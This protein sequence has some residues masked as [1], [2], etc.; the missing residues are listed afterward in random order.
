MKVLL[1]N[2]TK[3]LKTCP[4]MLPVIRQAQ[5]EETDVIAKRFR[6]FAFSGE[7]ISNVCFKACVFENCRL[8]DCKFIKTDFMDAV[9]ISCDLS[10]SDFSDGYFNRCQFSSCKGVGVNMLDGSVQNVSLQSSNFMYLNLG[11]TTAKNIC[12]TDSDLSHA[13]ITGCRQTDVE[14]ADVKLIGTSFFTTPLKG[15]DFTK[16]QI[17]GMIVSESGQE[18]KGAVVSAY[19]ASELAKLLGLIIKD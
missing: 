17:D 2:L 6:G 16:C 13:G 8:I 9:F 3:E 7:D 5:E 15:L 14:L 19:Q 4:D 18:L 10:G 1:P 12:V 11:K